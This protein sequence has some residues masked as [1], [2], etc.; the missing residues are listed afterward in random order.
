VEAASNVQNNQGASEASKKGKEGG[1]E[2]DEGR[3]EGRSVECS[4]ERAIF[5][6]NA[7][8]EPKSLDRAAIFDFKAH[9][10]R[11]TKPK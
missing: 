10:R 7:A 4:A 5:L 3:Q 1:Q 6:V 2:S 8:A 11:R 9:K